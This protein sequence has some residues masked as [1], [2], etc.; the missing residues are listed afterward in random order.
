[1]QMQENFFFF[2]CFFFTAVKMTF[3]LLTFDI[4]FKL[5]KVSNVKG[6][7]NINGHKRTAAQK[8]SLKL[9]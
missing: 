2:F 7:L 5:L 6:H 8:N 4:F 3:E 1:M 9:T